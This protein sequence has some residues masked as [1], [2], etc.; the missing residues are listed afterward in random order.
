MTTA[1]AEPCASTVRPRCRNGSCEPTRTS[2]VFW[3]AARTSAPFD[4]AARALGA[5]QT[6]T[7]N[8]IPSPSAMAWL[9]LLTAGS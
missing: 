4:S 9:S 6:S 7:T 1:S 2:F 8:E 3:V 5:S